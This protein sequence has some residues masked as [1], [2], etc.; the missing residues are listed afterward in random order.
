MKLVSVI[1]E[2]FVLPASSF[3]TEVKCEL[4]TFFW[5]SSIQGVPKWDISCSHYRRFD[6]IAGL[7]LTSTVRDSE[8]KLNGE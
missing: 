5:T 2:N 6:R 1:F 4:Y 3:S 7:P 8:T